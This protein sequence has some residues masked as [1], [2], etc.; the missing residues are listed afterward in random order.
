MKLFE[1]AC[2]RARYQ[3][4]QV[5]DSVEPASY[6]RGLKPIDRVS[7][8]RWQR[9]PVMDRISKVDRA[10]ARKDKASW[11]EKLG[12]IPYPRKL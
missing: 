8:H 7:K 10:Q 1:A 2:Y 3:K 12:W 5:V 9:N 6:T 4:L 11:T